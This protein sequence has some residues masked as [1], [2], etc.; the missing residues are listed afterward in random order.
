MRYRV[1]DLPVVGLGA[2]APLPTTNPVAS[3]FGT[4][5]RT[6]TLG[7]V[8]VHD[9]TVAIPTISFDPKTQ[10]SNCAPDVTLPSIYVAYA[11]NMGP[12][13]DA[14]IGMAMRRLAP[15]P[16]PATRIIYSARSAMLGKKVAGR[17]QVGQPRGFQRFPWRRG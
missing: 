12:A 5:K 17:R 7:L 3:S 1:Q 8:P 6:S 10:S 16:I 11:D 13:A 9:G 4:V 15:L 14:G 2:F